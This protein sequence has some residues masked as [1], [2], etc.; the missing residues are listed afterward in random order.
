MRLLGKV[1]TCFIFLGLLWLAGFSWFITQISRQESAPPPAADIIVV[2]T[3]GAHRLDRG[4]AL[5]AE[6][7]APTLFITGV[8]K[9][10]RVQDVLEQASAR[11]RALI[12]HQRKTASIILGQEAENTIG[13]A[14]ETARWLS[15]KPYRSLLLVTSNYHMPRSVNE[16][17]ALLAHMRIIPAPVIADEMSDDDWWRNKYSR[18]LILAEYHKFLASKLRHWLVTAT[19]QSS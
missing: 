7:K 5:L 6:G 10:V 9:G 15:D 12:M 8:G 2:L 14:E 18:N 17:T 16:F 11:Q 19:K 13:N 3:G 1:F 4:L